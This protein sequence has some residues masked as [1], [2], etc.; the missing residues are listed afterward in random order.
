[1]ES[2]GPLRVGLILLV[3]A[4]WFA[5]RRYRRAVTAGT[6]AVLV[7]FGANV[8]STIVRRGAKPDGWWAHLDP[9]LI[10]LTTNLLIVVSLLGLVLFRLYIEGYAEGRAIRARLRA[11]VTVAISAAIVMCGATLWA[12]ATGDAMN[13]DNTPELSLPAGLFSL[14]GR[15]Y[16]SWVFIETGIWA[17]RMLRRTDVP[18][19]IGLGFI[20]A[21]TLILGI[22]GTGV[23]SLAALL[24]LLGISVPSTHTLVATTDGI[25]AIGLIAGICLPVLL[26]RTHALALWLRYWRLHQRLAPLHDAIRVLYPELVLNTITPDRSVAMMRFHARRRVTECS[27][28]LARLTH[29]DTEFAAQLAEL[30]RQHHTDSIATGTRPDTVATITSTLTADTRA[31]VHLSQAVRKHLTL[32]T[33]T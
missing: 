4:G 8:T 28:G 18:T 25:G 22:A 21:G 11:P 3:L 20:A 31:L 6:W 17:L 2:G 1:M 33:T 27:D 23:D 24:S 5:Y 14:T 26:G 30:A 15:V 29:P 13:M 19:R 32:P 10:T 9:R 7:A 12:V 16:M